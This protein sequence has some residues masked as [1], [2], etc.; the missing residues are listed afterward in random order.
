MT[1]EDVAY[2]Y[3][4]SDKSDLVKLALKSIKS[5]LKFTSKENVIIF[6]TPPRSKKNLLKLEK[7]STVKQVSNLTDPF[8]VKDHD[9]GRYGEKLHLC[10]VDAQNVVF[11]DCDTK[12]KRDLTCLLDEDYDFAARKEPHQATGYDKLRRKVFEKFGKKVISIPN[13]GFMI[14]KNRLHQRIAKDWKRFLVDEFGVYELGDAVEQ[15]SLSL[16]LS[17]KKIKW[18]SPEFCPFTW[19]WESEKEAF[20]VHGRTQPL[21]RRARHCLRTAL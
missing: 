16:C 19:R 11:L 8:F 10:S 9:A 12:V 20:V 14:F 3:T 7:L 17:D 15:V 1:N 5:L 4:L 13:T 18:L 6:Y 2:V 21:W